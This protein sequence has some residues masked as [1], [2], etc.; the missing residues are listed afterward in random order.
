LRTLAIATWPLRD[1]TNRILCISASSCL[2]CLIMSMQE[3]F[4][5]SMSYTQYS[6]FCMHACLCRPISVA[7]YAGEHVQASSAIVSNMQCP[8]P[9]TWNLFY[10]NFQFVVLY[11]NWSWNKIFLWVVHSMFSEI[12]K[13]LKRT[14]IDA[15]VK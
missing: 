4:K 1:I 15:S 10:F 9:P 13:N 11:T 12:I 6:L 14:L 7:F 2:F 8:H 5:I 3:S